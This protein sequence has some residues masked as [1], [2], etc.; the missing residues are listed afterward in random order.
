MQCNRKTVY[1]IFSFWVGNYRKQIIF[2]RMSKLGKKRHLWTHKKKKR[3]G[4]ILLIKTKVFY[5]CLQAYPLRWSSFSQAPRSKIL[6]GVAQCFIVDEEKNICKHVVYNIS[7]EC[8][9]SQLTQKFNFLSRHFIYPGCQRHFTL[10]GWRNW[11]PKP[12][13]RISN[14]ALFSPL[15]IEKTSSIQSTS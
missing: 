11:A 6:S 12:G 7:D 5:I 8:S 3:I 4:N 13:K 14:L 2:K 10:W 1:C 15:M 9:L